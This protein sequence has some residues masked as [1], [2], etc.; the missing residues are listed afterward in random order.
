MFLIQNCITHLPVVAWAQEGNVAAI[1]DKVLSH[2]PTNLNFA[3]QFASFLSRTRTWTPLF[4]S[5]HALIG[6]MWV[7]G[8]IDNAAGTYV[9]NDHTIGIHT[10]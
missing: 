6:K 3:G 5:V 9:N 2:Q 8:I 1:C 10:I 7:Y 4:F